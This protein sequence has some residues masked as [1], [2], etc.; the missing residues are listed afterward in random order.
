[1]KVKHGL[2]LL[3]VLAFFAAEGIEAQNAG[4]VEVGATGRFTIFDDDLTAGSAATVD[5][6]LGVGARAGFFIW[7]NL[8]VEGEWSYAEPGTDDPVRIDRGSDFISHEQISGRLVYNAPLS[9]QLALLVGGGYTYDNY[10]RIRGVAP[11]GGGPAG[12]LGL[13]YNI[14]PRFSGRVEATGHFVTEDQDRFPT[15]RESQFNFGLQAGLSAMFRHEVETIVEE[16]PAPPPDTVVVE[17]EVEP[18]LPTGEPANICLATGEN[19]EI[20][21]TPQGDTLVGPQRVRTQDLG[22]GVAFQGNYAE[23]L[24]WFDTDE[25]IDFDEH[26]YV[27]FGGEVSLDCNDIMQVGEYR[28]VPLFAEVGAERPYETIYVPVRPGV[29]QAYETTPEVRG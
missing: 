27:K 8:A 21:I 3:A 6:A 23:G 24:D 28:G 16:T 9:P 5:N 26:E 2:A 15:G 12:L 25:A 22:P 14:T 1:M 17:R 7:Q 11:R 19:V 4:A 29:W 13:R 18:E 10:T 20:L